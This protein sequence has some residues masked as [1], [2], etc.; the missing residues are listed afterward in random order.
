[1]SKQCILSF[2]FLG[3][4]EF[5]ISFALSTETFG[6]LNNP[7]EDVWLFTPWFNIGSLPPDWSDSSIDEE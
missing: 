1:M 4:W 5:G 7:I 2:N 3:Y 6:I